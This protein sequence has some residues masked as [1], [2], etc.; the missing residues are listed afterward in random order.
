MLVKVPKL[1]QSSHADIHRIPQCTCFRTRFRHANV[2][3][4][5]AA[6]VRGRGVADTGKGAFGGLDLG[7]HDRH[8]P[9]VS[10]RYLEQRGGDA[11]QPLLMRLVK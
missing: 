6:H 2:W 11:T 1:F 9:I 7:S 4:N 8:M 5:H 3:R 10:M